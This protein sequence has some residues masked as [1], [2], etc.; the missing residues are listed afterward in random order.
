MNTRIKVEDEIN[1]ELPRRLEDFGMNTGLKGNVTFRQNKNNT[2]N[3]RVEDNLKR[4]YFFR[5]TAIKIEK[6]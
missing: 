6:M 4:S 5:M 3:K 1:K 2:K